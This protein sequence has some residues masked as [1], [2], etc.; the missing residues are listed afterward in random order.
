MA[1][2]VIEEWP[3]ALKDEVARTPREKYRGRR[4]QWRS[5]VETG[6]RSTQL[7]D[8][9]MICASLPRLRFCSD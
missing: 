8:G 7:E 4:T 6:N 3:L 2:A 9:F 5:E 1:G